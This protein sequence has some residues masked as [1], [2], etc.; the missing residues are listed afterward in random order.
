MGDH[1]RFDLVTFS[2]GGNDIGFGSILQHCVLHEIQGC[3]SDS[4]VRQKIK[5]LGTSGVYKGSL[6]IPSY[7]TFLLHVATSAVEANGNIVV[8]GYPEIFESP[9]LWGPGQGGSC[10]GLSAKAIYTARGWAGDLN[11]TIAASVAE[12]NAIPATKRNNVHFTFVDPVSGGGAIAPNDPNLLEP[13]SGTRHELCSQGHD[14]WMNG[15]SERHIAHSFHPNQDG[16]TAMGALAA[17][18]I[19]GLTWPNSPTLGVP[20]GSGQQGYGTV[21]PTTVFNGGDP[22]GLVSGVTW[23]AWGGSKATGTGTSDYVGPGQDVASGTQEP[24][25]IVAFDPGVCGGHHAYQAVEWYFPQNGESFDP[26]NYINICSGTYVGPLNNPTTTTSTNNA[27]GQWTGSSLTISPTSLGAVTIGMSLSQAQQAA[28]VAF[29]GTGDG[30]SYPTTLPSGFPHDF[31]S[32]IP[33][34]TCLGAEAKQPA[35]QAVSTPEG[36]Q[37]GQSVQTLLSIYG[38]RATYKPAPTQGGMTNNAGYV[39]SEGSGNLVF[40]V[41]PDGSTITEIAGGPNIGPNTCT[42]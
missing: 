22:T 25:T 21:E 11:A 24:V 31:V 23:Q 10:A 1:G 17:E 15:F 16:E 36:F 28:G 18:V 38:S 27:S 3:P 41:G 14:T 19:G 5:E 29:D 7:P 42:G 34:V 12:M 8:M 4:A 35:S 40:V 26:N 39:V 37:L 13:S 30:F 6:H 2:F 33:T 20:W 32:G 9:N